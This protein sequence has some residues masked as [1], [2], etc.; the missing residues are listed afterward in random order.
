MNR[1]I[2]VILC[3]GNWIALILIAQMQY[4]SLTEALEKQ[5]KNITEPGEY[6]A[7]AALRS[8]FDKLKAGDT[9]TRLSEI[10]ISNCILSSMQI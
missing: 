3:K 7:T 2:T 1:W 10:C 8:D 9:S 5:E 4:K 6:D